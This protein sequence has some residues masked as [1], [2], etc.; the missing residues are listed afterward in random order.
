MAPLAKFVPS[1]SRAYVVPAVSV[2]VAAEMLGT[3]FHTL[4]CAEPVVVGELTLMAVT[5]TVS[6]LGKLAGGVYTPPLL[7]VP[8]LLLPPVTP[9]TCH[10]TDVVGRLVTLA[11]KVVVLPMR[12]CALPL[13]ATAGVGFAARL[14]PLMAKTAAIASGTAIAH[15]NKERIFFNVDLQRTEV[16][17]AATRVDGLT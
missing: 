13:T 5:V 2:A 4:T 17:S 8:T 15:T 11:M 16:R 10:V 3:G 14:Q 12:T 6:G 7:I 9:F 1:T